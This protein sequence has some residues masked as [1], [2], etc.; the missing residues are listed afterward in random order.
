MITLLQNL[1]S[2]A[3][4]QV[5][6]YPFTSFARCGRYYLGANSNG[7]YIIGRDTDG[8]RLTTFDGSVINAH[9]TFN[10]DLG[11]DARVHSFDLN[12]ESTGDLKIGQVFNQRE[13]D[14]EVFDVEPTQTG[15]KQH[16]VKINGSPRSDYGQNLRV[17][18]SNVN[19]CDFSVDAI[20]TALI[21]TGRLRTGR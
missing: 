7:L 17:K 20:R 10:V 3:I 12:M 16:R 13:S 1:N 21:P 4:T 2:T 6:G 11:A 8:D 15:L 5:T 18:V 9:F 19:G 14:E